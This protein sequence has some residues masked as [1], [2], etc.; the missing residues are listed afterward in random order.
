MYLRHQ[1][2]TRIETAADTKVDTKMAEGRSRSS[3]TRPSGAAASGFSVGSTGSTPSI[4]PTSALGS[5]DEVGMG[6]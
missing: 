3:K 1:T 4:T 2:T 5:Q 6:S